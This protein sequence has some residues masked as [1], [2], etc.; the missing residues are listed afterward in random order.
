MFHSLKSIRAKLTLWYSF[1]LLTTLAACGLFAYEY[2][3]EKLTVSLDLSLRNEV[4]FLKN[5]FSAKPKHAKI[6]KPN[7]AKISPL[8]P[9]DRPGSDTAFS[10]DEI[11]HQIYE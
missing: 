7:V 2:S 1:I 5:F 8:S 10:D 6:P 3:R 11:W 9:A 4:M